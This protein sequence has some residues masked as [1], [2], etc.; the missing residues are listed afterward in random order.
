MA[1]RAPD[2]ANN[3]ISYMRSQIIITR[4]HDDKITFL[5]Q[6]LRGVCRKIWGGCNDVMAVIFMC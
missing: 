6:V 1:I 2:G 5:N 3:D 4:N